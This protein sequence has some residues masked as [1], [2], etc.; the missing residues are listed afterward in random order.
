M[1]KR[2]L[3]ILLSLLLL[4]SVMPVAFADGGSLSN[5]EKVRTYE[6]GQFTDNASGQW[7]TD[8]IISAYEFGLVN[9]KG[10]SKFDT[11]GNI[12]IAET[13]ALA[14]R[15]HSIYYTGS[16][17]FVQIDPWYEVYMDYAVE[18]GIIEAGE[19]TNINKK[20]TRAQF[21]EI[22]AAALPD[23][24][25]EAIN[26]VE[27]GDI[28]DVSP[29]ASYAD[30]VYKLYNAGVLTGNDEYGTFT[31]DANIQRCAVAT[32]VT[33]MAD[34][35]K[36]VSLDL[37]SAETVISNEY[38][39]VTIPA[40]WAGKYVCE[41][42]DDME[43]YDV[44]TLAFYDRAN[45]YAD[46][47]Y[48]GLLFSICLSPETYSEEEYVGAFV[49]RNGNHHEMSISYPLDVQY[50]LNMKE[51]YLTLCKQIGYIIE[52][53]EPASGCSLEII[54]NDSTWQ[55]QYA[56]IINSYLTNDS[57]YNYY[58]YRYT[59]YDVD[60]NGIPELF[61]R[62][63]TCEADSEFNVFTFKSVTKY[64]DYY[65]S[66]P[67]GH[68]ALAGVEGDNSIVFFYGHM[69]YETLTKYTYRE[70]LFVGSELFS[71]EMENYHDLECLAE[72]ALDDL[73]GLNWTGNPVTNNQHIIDN[74]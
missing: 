39:S 37:E 4:C 26:N 67:A 31:P 71:G 60:K 13:V 63:G 19:Y 64:V 30:A 57:Q 58:G 53:I 3:S 68:T 24:A 40:T 7:Y 61:I 42:Y 38:F 10:D 54:G 20:A 12:T 32:I 17:D 14:S 43:N 48:G 1:K 27:K 29:V 70:G 25:L 49:D 28:S 74:V 35:S 45:Y 51:P 18:N 36:R 33:R 6:V 69:G 65:G 9:G 41:E 2:I 59:L 62:V 52:S 8:S 72:Y 23:E 47:Y 22:L 11:F 21:A 66:F 15:L 16:G 73:S 5:F 34:E 50:D 55:E 44:Y 56:G 46:N